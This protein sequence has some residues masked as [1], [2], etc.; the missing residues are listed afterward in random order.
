MCESSSYE[1]FD[2]KTHNMVRNAIKSVYS[3]EFEIQ[4]LLECIVQVH[5][6]YL[7]AVFS[8]NGL[9]NFKVMT[10]QLQFESMDVK[11]CTTEYYVNFSAT[12]KEHIWRDKYGR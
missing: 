12:S 10:S 5:L 2:P 9:Q 11:S 3:S 4:Y 1:T 6:L 8:W 7:I